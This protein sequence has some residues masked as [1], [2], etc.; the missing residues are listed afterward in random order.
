V[1]Q[2]ERTSSTNRKKYSKVLGKMNRTA[3]LRDLEEDRPEHPVVEEEPAHVEG[4]LVGPVAQRGEVGD[5]EVVDVERLVVGLVTVQRDGRELL[6]DALVDGVEDE[7]REQRRH[8]EVGDQQREPQPPGHDEDDDA[9]LD[10]PH[11]SAPRARRRR[12]SAEIAGVAPLGVARRHDRA[13]CRDCRCDGR[14]GAG[15]GG[16]LEWKDSHRVTLFRRRQACPRVSSPRW[17]YRPEAST[18]ACR[19]VKG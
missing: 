13:R 6:E 18:R 11:A 9:P 19:R 7:A 3:R 4:G 14:D 16:T 12:P 2:R 1:S 17:W 10:G 8:G 5:R 15:A